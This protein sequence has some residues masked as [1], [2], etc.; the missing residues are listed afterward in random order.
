M[1]QQAK[2]IF[3]LSTIYT[4]LLFSVTAQ[5]E[6]PKFTRADTLRGS[7]NAER[8]YNVLKYDISITPDFENKSIQ[9]K[10]TITYIDSGLKTMQI[11]LQV[12]LEI[13]SIIQYEGK[14]TFTREGNVFHVDIWN[15]ANSK[16]LKSENC[17]PCTRQIT[18]YYHGNQQ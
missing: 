9:G 10:N 13:D 8:S 7:L 15:D 12:P 5:K 1:I 2:R 17:R 11:D 3:S 4:L 16:I 18:I 14:L 6:K